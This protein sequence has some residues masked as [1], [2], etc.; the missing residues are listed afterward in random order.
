MKRELLRL[1]IAVAVFAL[2]LGFSGLAYAGDDDDDDDSKDL[3]D[4][5]GAKLKLGYWQVSL[6]GD[7]YAD[8]NG[9]PGT[10]ID[11]D[12]KDFV[13]FDRAE[14]TLMPELQ[15]DVGPFRINV[16]Y[17]RF[18]F[19]AGEIGFANDFAFDGVEI[20][21]SLSEWL[22]G[23]LFLEEASVSVGFNLLEHIDE[24]DLWGGVG[25]RM[26]GIGAD[27]QAASTVPA[28]IPEFDASRVER[29]PVPVLE[30]QGEIHLTDWFDIGMRGA[31]INY[32]SVDI[33]TDIN[34]FDIRAYVG[35]NAEFIGVEV[36]YHFLRLDFAFGDLEE[37]P[38]SFDGSLGGAYIF[39]YLKF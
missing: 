2:V 22:E 36:G 11:F 30:G 31:W 35:F 5:L 37:D 19:L 17:W 20:P 27:F 23:S 39:A 3:D 15:L 10:K 33:D 1:I 34:L 28:L 8:K 26:Y 4:E 7:F 13:D 9:T 32:R 25:A 24:I 29:M 12:K 18:D 14:A 38:F 6:Q 16:S 21:G